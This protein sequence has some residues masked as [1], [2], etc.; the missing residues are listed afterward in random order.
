MTNVNTR[1]KLKWSEIIPKS[2]DIYAK[3]FW[4]SGI[5]FLLWMAWDNLR[6]WACNTWLVLS[7]NWWNL[8]KSM[9]YTCKLRFYSDWNG[10]VNLRPISLWSLMW[11][12]NRRMTSSGKTMKLHNVRILQGLS[13]NVITYTKSYLY[14]R[15]YWRNLFY[16]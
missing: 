2:K 15:K 6:S 14:L 7:R 5:T 9:T 16:N 13:L 3:T 8:I 1:L 12:N 11:S 10:F 4:K